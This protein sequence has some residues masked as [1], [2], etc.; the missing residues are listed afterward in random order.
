MSSPGVK[1]PGSVVALGAVSP[2][3][4]PY[5][6]PTRRGTA[7]TRR[8]RPINHLYHL[9]HRF[10]GYVG[11]VL[12]DPAGGSPPLVIAT[13]SY[14]MVHMVFWYKPKDTAGYSCTR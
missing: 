12:V 4:Q 14:S 13:Y 3:Y 8:N 5:Q 11:T 10:S 7:G 1:L 9:Y 6:M 2:L